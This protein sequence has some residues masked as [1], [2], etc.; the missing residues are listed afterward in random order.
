MLVSLKII[1]GLENFLEEVAI[2]AGGD[3]LGFLLLVSLALIIINHFISL[4]AV[5]VLAWLVFIIS[6]I[7]FILWKIV[8]LQ[9][10]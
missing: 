8:N 1:M 10:K 7:I 4:G 3:G 5:G 9:N 2:F 6:F